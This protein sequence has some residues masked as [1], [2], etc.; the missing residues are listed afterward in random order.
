MISGR[1]CFDIIRA[2]VIWIVLNHVFLVELSNDI[3]ASREN[4]IVHTLTHTNKRFANMLDSTK[5]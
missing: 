5:N 2:T 1:L 4:A 3:E